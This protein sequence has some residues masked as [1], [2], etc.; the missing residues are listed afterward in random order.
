M[1]QASEADEVWSL[2]FG[3]G[4]SV[5]RKPESKRPRKRQCAWCLCSPGHSP[6][7]DAPQ[8]R[9]PES[10]LPGLKMAHDMVDRAFRVCCYSGVSS[11]ALRQLR[12]EIV[13]AIRREEAKEKGKR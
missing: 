6:T 12:G 5:P 3:E 13:S 10:K 11:E 4:G 2:L 8:F 9:P 7:C 1:A